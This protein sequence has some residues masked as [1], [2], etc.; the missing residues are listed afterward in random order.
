M[1]WQGFLNLALLASSLVF[2]LQS[3]KEY[4]QGSTSYSE[5]T[6]SLTLH[7][8]PTLVICF[9]RT[10]GM[11]VI[12]NEDDFSIDITI[13]KITENGSETVTLEKNRYVKTLHNLE[14]QLSDLWTSTNNSMPEWFAYYRQK[15]HKITSKWSGSDSIDFARFAIKIIFKFDLLKENSVPKEAYMS[16]TSEAN[17]FGLVRGKWFDG[18]MQDKFIYSGAFI[19]VQQ[20]RE[21]KN[22]AATCSQA[23]YYEC[24]ALRFRSL[25]IEHVS[26]M[27]TNAICAPF[28]LPDKGNDIAVCNNKN[29]QTYMEY[30]VSKIESDQVHDCKKSCVL[31]EFI[32]SDPQTFPVN[33]PENFVLA[34]TFSVQQPISTPK[35]SGYKNPI[36]M[37]YSEYFIMS[38]M[39]LV[40][41]VGGTF[42][43]F[44]GFSFFDSTEW[45]LTGVKQVKARYTK[46]TLINRV[47]QRIIAKINKYE[48]VCKPTL[49]LCFL[50]VSMFISKESF[51]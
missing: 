17:S 50:G 6:E 42:G 12:S 20:V 16:V 1:A 24:L 49:Y 35:N 33:E 31:K 13:P 45:I 14:L 46:T 48:S 15:C 18:N 22:L 41:I 19:K 40:G 36:K 23:S 7:D 32:C 11:D 3:C 43:M 28:S 27:T 2:V 26:E 29:D 10:D 8:L 47:V 4:M 9:L 38:A 21:Y 39:T 51:M 25:G 5:T 30:V 44:I 34:Y 37:V